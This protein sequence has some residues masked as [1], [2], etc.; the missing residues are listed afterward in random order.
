MSIYGSSVCCHHL[1]T[2]QIEIV[3]APIISCANR[4]AHA[5]SASPPL[6][7]FR[8][9]FL[10]P[11]TTRLDVRWSGNHKQIL[12]TQHQSELKY[13]LLLQ[14]QFRCIVCQWTTRYHY[15]GHKEGM[16]SI[17]NPVRKFDHCN[18]IRRHCLCIYNIYFRFP[19]STTTH[20]IR[21]RG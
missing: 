11:S 16:E 9:L 18:W 3:C 5:E 8:Q 15:L 12:Q 10:L 19:A 7:L 13:N 1:I 2:H 14:F 6:C 17:R 20:A 21:P 4:R